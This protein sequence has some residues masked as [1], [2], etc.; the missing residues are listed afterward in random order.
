MIW[1]TPSAT[2]SPARCT[3]DSRGAG[4][5]NGAVYLD[6]TQVSY[7]GLRD[8]MGEIIDDSRRRVSTCGK[9]R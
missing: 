3:G 9:S 6:L 8:V 2:F 1:S 5:E 4:T 7:E